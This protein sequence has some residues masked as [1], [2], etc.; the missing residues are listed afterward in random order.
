MKL[1]DEFDFGHRSSDCCGV[2]FCVEL[3]E[4]KK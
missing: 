3:K 4:L 1:N 2:F